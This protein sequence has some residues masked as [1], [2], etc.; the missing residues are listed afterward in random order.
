MFR[1]YNATFARFPDAG[2]LEYWI[3]HFSSGSISDKS[4]AQSFIISKEFGEMYGTNVSN[5]T[6][7][8]NLYINV[9]GRDYDPGGFDFW[10]GQLN[11][12]RERNQLLLDFAESPENKGLFAEMTGFG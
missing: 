10:L 11:N 12:G 2:G 4:V 5:E 8:E 3:D 1:L 7:L 6:Y 9:L